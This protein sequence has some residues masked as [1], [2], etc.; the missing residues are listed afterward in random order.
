MTVELK[1]WLN[2]INL[3]KKDLIKED[4]SVEKKYPA[5]II[6]KCMAGHIDTIMFANEMNMYASLDRD[7]QYEFYLNIAIVNFKSRRVVF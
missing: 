6:N 5:Y 3:N 4:P 2:S 7:L 1:D